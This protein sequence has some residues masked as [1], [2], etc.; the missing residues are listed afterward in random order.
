M[1]SEEQSLWGTAFDI[2]GFMAAESS[3]SILKRSAR[4]GFKVPFF[5]KRK[6]GWGAIGAPVDVRTHYLKTGQFYDISSHIRRN[7]ALGMYEKAGLSGMGGAYKNVTKKLG[8]EIAGSIGRRYFIG[9]L[10]GLAIPVANTFFAASFAYDA[11]TVPYQIMSGVVRQTK[12]LELGGYY[13]DNQQSYTSR[14]RAVKA[15]TSSQLQARSA[16]GNEGFLMHR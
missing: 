2:G 7:T 16:I 3:L 15:I 5:D 14:Q 11:V 10:A 1:S 13:F 9:R 6:F 4:K 8:A 12:G